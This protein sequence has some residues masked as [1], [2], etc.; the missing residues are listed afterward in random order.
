M[1]GQYQSNSVSLN[2]LSHDDQGFDDA[3]PDSSRMSIS[4][5]ALSF[6]TSVWESVTQTVGNCLPFKAESSSAR[7]G[8]REAEDEERGSYEQVVG[9]YGSGNDRIIYDADEMIRPS[10]DSSAEQEPHSTAEGNKLQLPPPLPP[11]KIPLE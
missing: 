4:T 2:N 8:D 10:I 7:E 5:G 1:S 3:R 6:L 9:R 11:Q